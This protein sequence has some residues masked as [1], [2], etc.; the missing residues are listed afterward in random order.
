MSGHLVPNAH[1]GFYCVT[2]HYTTSNHDCADQGSL[3]CRVACSP[4]S[5][6]LFLFFSLS[7]SSFINRKRGGGN[8]E[9]GE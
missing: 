7:P 4:C 2:C 6:F 9:E 1:A 8:M 5:W 3:H